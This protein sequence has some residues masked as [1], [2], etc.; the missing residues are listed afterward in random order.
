MAK[1]R[2]AYERKKIAQSNDFLSYQ[3]NSDEVRWKDQKCQWSN[4]K[5]IRA[6]TDKDIRMKLTV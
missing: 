4:W 5:D 2:V 3:Q 6:C 1:S